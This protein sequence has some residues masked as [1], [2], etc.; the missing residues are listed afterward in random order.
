MTASDVL[1]EYLGAFAPEYE[2]TTFLT[3]H[4]VA[5]DKTMKVTKFTRGEFL[6]LAL[7]AAHVLSWH[8]IAAGNCHTHFFSK[9]SVG[10]LALSLIHI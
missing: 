4:E 5:A 1:T 2:D 10:D 8:G 6:Q 3:Y 7:K 9:N